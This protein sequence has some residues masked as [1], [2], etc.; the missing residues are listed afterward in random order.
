MAFNG[1]GVFVRLYNWVNDAAAAINITASRMD[2]ET[3]GIA[4]GLSN[5]ITRDGQGKPSAAIDWN[6]QN[7]S[8]VA[9]LS[10][11]GNTIL[12]DAVTDTLN[13]GAGGIIKTAAG[14]VGIG[15]TPN[16]YGA[17]F[18]CTT[19]NAVTSSLFDLNVS[20]V[21]TAA[22]VANA[23]QALIGSMTNI[24]FVIQQNGTERGRFDGNG[25]FGVGATAPAGNRLYLFT[26]TVDTRVALDNSTGGGSFNLIKNGADG[27]IDLSTVAGA[28]VFRTGSSTER[29][30]IDGNGNWM[31]GV[32]GATNTPAHGISTLNIA[33]A[34]QFAVGHANGTATGTGYNTFAYNAGLIGSITQSGTT[35]VLYN[36][37]SDARLKTSIADASDAGAIIDAIRVRSFNWKSAPDERVTHGFIAQEL[38]SVAPQAVK[39]GDDGEDVTDVW[40]VDPSKLVPLLVKELQACRARLAALEG[41]R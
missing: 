37:T 26:N 7:L 32:S 35:A 11:T 17:G 40:A 15:G 8:N 14:D 34:T 30:R 22:F 38:A 4:A 6:G 9:N 31:V 29:A 24:P 18:I 2:A 19:V 33:D 28:L 25:N 23:A 21:R 5:C 10:T 20:N 12:G 16:A 39:V 41:A 36:T 1:A 13:I 27:L 3:D